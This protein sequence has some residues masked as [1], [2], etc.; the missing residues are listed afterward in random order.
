MCA[1]TNVKY[2]ITHVVKGQNTFTCLLVLLLILFLFLRLFFCSLIAHRTSRCILA[3]CL[4]L[5]GSTNTMNLFYLWYFLLLD[6]TL[7]LFL[8]ILIKSPVGSN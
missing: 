2:F 5:D 8:Y 3:A 1:K 6:L 7:I 4:L